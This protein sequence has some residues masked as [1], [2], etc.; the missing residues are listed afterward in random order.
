MPRRQ[1]K[2]IP[3]SDREA[4]THARALHALALMRRENLSR[5]EACRQAH[6]KP[7]TF[8]RRVGSALRQDRPGGRYRALNTDKF[9]RDL[10]VP[11]VL[12]PMSVPVQGLKNACEVSQY[13]N[14]VG[15]Y[16]RTGKTK[17]L[18]RFKGKRVGPRGQRVELVT[19]PDTLTMLAEA[20]ALQLDQ[21]Y[22]AFAGAL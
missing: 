21:L 19:D 15:T 17:Q 8:S 20:G 3:Q 22:S 18:A 13:S 6:I 11:T 7:A 12:G 9:R 4:K 16:L 1:R 10:Q 2:P 14:A 5:A